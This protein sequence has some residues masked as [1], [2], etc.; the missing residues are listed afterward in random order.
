MQRTDL[1]HFLL[2]LRGIY[3][4][5]VHMKLAEYLDEQGLTRSQFADLI[6]VSQETVR[7]YLNEGRIPEPKVMTRIALATGCKVTA[8]DFFGIA[9]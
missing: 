2:T 4:I 7:R 9:A 3:P 8:N 6:E 5:P 1:L